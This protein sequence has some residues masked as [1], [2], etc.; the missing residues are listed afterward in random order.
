M[1]NTIFE[2]EKNVKRVLYY[3]SIMTPSI[4][5]NHPSNIA[6]PTFNTMNYSFLKILTFITPSSTVSDHTPQTGS[7]SNVT[8]TLLTVLRTRCGTGLSIKA[9]SCTALFGRKRENK[10][11]IQALFPLHVSCNL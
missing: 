7:L 9:R 8:V 2:T 3:L 10:Y 6:I 5:L 11:N 1:L 4:Q